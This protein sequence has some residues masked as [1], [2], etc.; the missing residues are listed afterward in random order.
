VSS[1]SSL[2]A[3]TQQDIVSNENAELPYVNARAGGIPRS[4]E[5]DL[6]AVD[7][8]PLSSRMAL[9]DLSELEFEA[10]FFDIDPDVY[11]AE[12][13]NCCGFVPAIPGDSTDGGLTGSTLSWFDPITLDSLSQVNSNTVVEPS[14]YGPTG[15]TTTSLDDSER[16]TA[17]L[18]RY[19]V[20][21]ISPCLDVFD[22]ERYFGHV[23]PTKTVRSALLRNSLAAVAA[24]QFGKTKREGLSEIGQPPSVAM[25]RR[26][27]DSSDINWFYKAAS[28]YDKAIGYVMERLHSLQHA[29][30]VSTVND[31]PTSQDASPAS[32]AKSSFPFKRRRVE[33][34]RQQSNTAD[35]L[36]AAISVFLLYELL[37]NRQTEMFQYVSCQSTSLNLHR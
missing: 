17:Y 33:R 10:T 29:E 32:A 3:P 16:E 19:F 15:S 11:F 25:L 9:D 5:N 28:F 2:Q 20:E 18:V 1:D 36:L 13:N 26:H 34:S 27:F 23:V 8:G 22:V 21:R 35:D 4:L 12:G 31:S 30:S 6:L 7:T 37:D 24:K 14:E